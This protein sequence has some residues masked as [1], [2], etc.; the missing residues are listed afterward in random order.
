MMMMRGH[1]STSLNPD[2][3]LQWWSLAFPCKEFHEMWKIAVYIFRFGPTIV[4]ASPY[5]K[6]LSQPYGSTLIESREFTCNCC[7]QRTCKYLTT[8]W[9]AKCQNNTLSSCAGAAWVEEF[10]SP[11]SSLSHPFVERENSWRKIQMCFFHLVSFFRH[12]FYVIN[13]PTR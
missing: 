4:R 7:S 2:M 12:K 9:G 11:L 10:F 1:R 5:V 6:I 13:T 8:I 3:I